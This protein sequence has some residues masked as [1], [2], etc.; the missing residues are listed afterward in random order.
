MSTLVSIKYVSYYSR[1]IRFYIA[2]RNLQIVSDFIKLYFLDIP[3]HSVR[4]LAHWSATVMTPL[5]NNQ[6]TS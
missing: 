3:V 1:I 2:I 4:K 5:G 6:Q